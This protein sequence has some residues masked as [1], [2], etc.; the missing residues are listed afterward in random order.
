MELAIERQEIPGA[1][2]VAVHQGKVIWEKAYGHRQL[3][4]DRKRTATDTI[5]DL[6]SLTKPIATAT[7]IM[8]LVEQGKLNVQ[9][10]VTKYIPEFGQ[11][12]K[13][14]ITD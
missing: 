7:S 5:F 14:I 6:A 1:V 13:D 3:Y 11:N 2:I 10:Y 8:I 4:P 9:D 12:G